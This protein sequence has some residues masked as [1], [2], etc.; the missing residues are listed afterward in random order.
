VNRQKLPKPMRDLAT[1]YSGFW[2]AVHR[3]GPC[4]TEDR[5]RRRGRDHQPGRGGQPDRRRRNPV[6]QLDGERAGYRGDLD[7]LPGADNPPL[8]VGE[9]CPATRSPSSPQAKIAMRSRGDVTVVNVT[10]MRS[11]LDQINFEGVSNDK[12]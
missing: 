8:G 2:A 12:I 5:R 7:F 6:H 1:H 11:T 4:A 3:G 10:Y 9:G